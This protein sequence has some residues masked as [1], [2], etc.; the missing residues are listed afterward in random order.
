MKSS[1]NGRIVHPFGPVMDESAKI[2]ILG[3]F[4]SVKSREQSFFYGHPH[5]RFWRVLAGVLGCGVP[6]TIEDKTDML[7]RHHIALWDVLQSCEIVGSSDAS[8]KNAVPN[9]LDGIL[10]TQKIRAVFSN[11]SASFRLYRK[12]IYPKNQTPHFLLPS[13]SP[14]NARYS[15][16]ALMQEWRAILAYL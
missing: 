10:K 6:Q 9:D 1:D 11:G 12:F 5:N 13:T 15:L 8:I 2:L 14:A 16:D 7:L 3:S 4:P